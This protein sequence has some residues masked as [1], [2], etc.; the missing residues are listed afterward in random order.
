MFNLKEFVLNNLIKGVKNGSFTKE[1]A[2][3]LATNY[4]LKGILSQE[5][6]EIFD[7]ETT[8]EEPVIENEEII[9]ET[10]VDPIEEPIEE[11]IEEN[12]EESEV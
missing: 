5:D 12:T 11:G 9:E 10:I 3:I 6:I 2:S 8:I 4:L 1:Y 7:I